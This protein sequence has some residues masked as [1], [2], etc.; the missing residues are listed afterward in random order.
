MPERG[1]SV[2]AI[3][4]LNLHVFLTVKGKEEECLCKAEG[5]Q[6]FIRSFV[7]MFKSVSLWHL[8]SSMYYYKDHYSAGVFWPIYF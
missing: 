2:A 4:I 3:H 5:S 7:G 8:R 6:S 1:M